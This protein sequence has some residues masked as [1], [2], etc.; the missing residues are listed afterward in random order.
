MGA[1]IVN[2]VPCFDGPNQDKYPWPF[3]QRKSAAPWLA[4][5]SDRILFMAKFGVASWRAL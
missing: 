4:F 3:P 5:S 2:V 1:L